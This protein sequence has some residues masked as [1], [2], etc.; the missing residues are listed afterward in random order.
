MIRLISIFFILSLTSCEKDDVSKVEE[1]S[2]SITVTGKWQSPQFTVPP[3]VHFTYF[4]G[5]VHDQNS[6]LWQEGSNASVGIENVAE[7]GGIIQLIQET[8]IHI[9]QQ[10]AIA[11]IAFPPPT[12]TGSVTSNIYCTSKHSNVSFASMIAPSPDWFIG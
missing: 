7:I 4:A 5:M 6:R 11:H 3:G 2:Y 12:A 9:A 8:D 1:A 10:K